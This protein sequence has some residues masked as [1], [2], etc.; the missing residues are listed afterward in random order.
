MDKEILVGESLTQD[1]IEAGAKLTEY[2]DKANL[3]VRAS[4]WFYL[5][6]SNAWRM[7]FALPEVRI[8]GPKKVYR[9]VQTVLKKIPR[10]QPTIALRDITVMDNLDP[11]IKL[12][13][14]ALKTGSGISGI[15]FSKNTIN[16]QQIEDAYIYRLA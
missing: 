2:L 10:G 9:K 13:S 11:L 12:F 1:M 8:D 3:M 4:L 15:R 6:D 14:S 7:I 5:T 16:G